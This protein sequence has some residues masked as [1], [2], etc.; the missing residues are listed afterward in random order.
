MSAITLMADI[1]ILNMFLVVACLPVVTAGAAVRAASV[2][3]RDMAAGV[4]SGYSMQFLRE[5]TQRWKPVTLYWLLLIALGATLAYQQWVVFHAGLGRGTLVVIEALA[6]S[7]AFIIAGVS[8]WFFALTSSRAPEARLSQL[9][10]DAVLATFRHLGRTLAAVAILLAGVAAV[11]ALPIAWAV[12]LTTFLVPAL[13]LYLIRLVVA[14]PLGE[15][16]GD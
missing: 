10:S 4:G 12:P 7:G 2:V 14:A 5:L 13:T 1:V 16:L 6:L 11:V 9:L 3:V 15:R 8:V